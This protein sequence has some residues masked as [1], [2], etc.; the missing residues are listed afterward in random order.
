[1][2]GDSAPIAGLMQQSQQHN[3]WLMID[4]AHGL[5]VLGDNGKGSVVEA[6]F[7]NNQLQIYMATF[8]KALGVSG[9]FVAGSQSFIDYL[10]NFSKPYIYTTG[11]PPAMAYTISCAAHMA[12]N[13]HWRRDKLLTLIAEFRHL[14]VLHDIELGDSQTA[15]QPLIIGDSK[16]ALH[17]AEQLKALGFWVTAIRP[18]TVP[19]NTARLRITLTSNHEKQDIKDLID[20]ISTILSEH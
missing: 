3:S 20:A 8:G 19:K 2:D 10:T 6:G 7:T 14:A 15:I 12:E 18:P 11:L 17:I 1:M 4:D 9:A 16:K 5:G 13:Q